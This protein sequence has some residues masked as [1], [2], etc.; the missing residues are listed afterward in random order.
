MNRKSNI[1]TKDFFKL[2]TSSSILLLI[3]AILAIIFANSP[4]DTYYNL[5]LNTPLKIELGALKISKP[6]LLWINDGLMAIFFF[7]IG[8]EL[9]REFYEGVLSDFH[10]V[11]LPL[12]GAIGGIIFPAGIFMLFNYDNPLTF[13]GWAIPIATDIAFSLGVLSLFGKKVPLGLKIFLMTL[14]IFDDIGA[15]IIIAIFYTTSISFQALIIIL[16]C[17]IIL[18][19][20]NRMNY[21]QKSLYITIGIVMWV[22]TLKSG[23][24]ATL[25]GILLA[26]FIPIKS[27][28][29]SEISPL[30]SLEKDLHFS[31]AFIILPIFAFSNSGIDFSNINFESLMHP[32]TLG[33]LLGLFI[34]KQ[35]GVFF[36]CYLFIKTKIV[37]LPKDITFINLY[38]VSAL[39]GI[40]FT[41]SLFIGTLAFEG[42]NIDT[43]LDKRLGILLGSLLS[44]ILGYYILR[45]SF[46]KRK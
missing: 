19:I 35:F 15:I 31:V 3:S 41:M 27:K 7:M 12:I 36:F 16:C 40:G 10:S 46:N 22:A 5:L 11:L 38:G 20:F 25:S 30:K 9:K 18:F 45:F 1:F 17:I 21:T 28:K 37:N 43:A 6:I 34:G 26:F 32:L 13:R 8:L 39:T 23:V 33:I 24:H 14:A 42:I 44:G 29:P 4:I 2:E